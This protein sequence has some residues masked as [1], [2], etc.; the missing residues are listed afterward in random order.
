MPDV[1]SNVDKDALNLTRSIGLAESGKNGVPDYNAVG[2]AGT[3]KGAYQWQ[4]GNYKAAA[5]EA[6]LDPNDFSPANQDKVAYYQVKKYKD[7]GLQPW[8]IASLWNS[9]SKD[10]W[11]NH[12]GTKM[13][14]GQVV[15][16]DTPAYVSRVKEH[17]SQLSGA[18]ASTGVQG[19]STSGSLAEG[20]QNL[21]N[22]LAGRVNDVGNAV[23]GTFTGKINPLSGALQSA[24]A[25]AGGINDVIGAG[26]EL[27]PGVKQ[28]ESF[29]GKGVSAL[30]QTG[31][32][33]AVMRGAEKFGQ[34]YPELTK[35]IQSAGNIAS[36]AFPLKGPGLVGRTAT[37]AA[38]EGL[39]GST[40]KGIADKSLTSKAVGLVAPKE[41]KTTLKNAIKSGRADVGGGFTGS[42]SIAPERATFE[43]GEAIKP[44]VQDGK[45]TAKKTAIENANA[46]YDEIGKEAQT[47]EAN[48][49]KG[50]IVPIVTADDLKGLT[51]RID[52]RLLEDPDL[53]GSA[54]ESASRMLKK[55]NTL[56]P[57]GR[58]ITALD[59]L[60]A[61]KAFD[62]WI[63][64]EGKS[65]L[66]DPATAN[67]KA[68]AARAIRREANA[69]LIEKAPDVAVKQSLARQS[70]LY[71]ALDSFA[72]RGVPEVG[73]TRLGR[74]AQNHPG[75]SGLVGGGI[76]YGLIGAGLGEGGSLVKGF[77][78]E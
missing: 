57:A 67:A 45:I 58:D 25:V 9:G 68:K 31:P 48:L 36:L 14:N 77:L 19:V 23:S 78:G 54:S 1:F 63:R 28:A 4:P 40:L 61:R 16:Y 47:L 65:K 51:Q 41:T 71:D 29:V 62:A 66:L 15:Q 56:L 52:A 50:D 21:G 76:K 17:Y 44:L 46:V 72:E 74:F 30:A 73:T 60:N 20:A 27:I 5:K 53:V 75:I 13:I 26:L 6:G 38:E 18:P 22:Q 33:Q 3:S 32:G 49:K 37:R 35:D 55:F 42:A 8:E 43:A 64:S 11:E 2:D 39:L 24:G 59:V 34:Q 12:K 69:L 7:Q 70:A 10:N